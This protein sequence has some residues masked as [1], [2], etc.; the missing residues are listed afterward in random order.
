[1]LRSVL[2]DSTVP[3]TP[4]SHECKAISGLCPPN[5]SDTD[6]ILASFLFENNVPNSLNYGITCIYG[7]LDENENFVSRENSESV[8]LKFER[9]Q[10]FLLIQLDDIGLTYTI[11]GWSEKESSNP[12]INSF[13]FNKF[14]DVSMY[15][16]GIVIPKTSINQNLVEFLK[17]ITSSDDIDT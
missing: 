15:T 1:M 12:N 5:N 9:N 2:N 3:K 11:L 10:F 8:K 14:V 13:E 4:D 17:S 6:L 16:G 7:A